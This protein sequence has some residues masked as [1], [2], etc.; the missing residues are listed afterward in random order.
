MPPDPA[1]ASSSRSDLLRRA[2]CQLAGFAWVMAMGRSEISMASRV[3]RSAECDMS[4]T[5]P[6]RFISLITPR[7]IRVTPGSSDS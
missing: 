7:P 3:E 1:S 5:S 4:T 6:T 2:G